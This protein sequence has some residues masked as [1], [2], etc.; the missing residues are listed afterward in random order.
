MLQTLERE[1][2]QVKGLFDRVE[3]VEEVAE[4]IAETS[5]EQADKLRKVALSALHDAAP[6][7]L[8]IAAALLD[9][10]SRTVH[11]WVSEGLLPLRTESPKRV[12]PETLHRVL[13]LVR[14]LRAAGKQR[15]LLDAVWYRLQDAT[16]LESA[17]L[18]TSLKQ[19]RR[20]ELKPALTRAEEASAK[21]DK[22]VLASK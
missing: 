11:S 7:R 1:K 8:S 12:D 2:E 14:E 4:A 16:L 22:G 3:E 20:G 19:L 13:H 9:L 17:E 18:Q 10:S 6:V 15:G 21:T 5:P